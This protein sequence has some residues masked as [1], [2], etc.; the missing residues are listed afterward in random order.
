VTLSTRSSSDESGGTGE[1]PFSIDPE[2]VVGHVHLKVSDLE[3][4]I[5]FYRDVLGFEVTQRMGERAAFLGAGGYHHHIGLNTWESA[6]GSAPAP[7]TTGL[8]HAAFRYPDRAAL[9][10]ALRRLIRHGV[11]LDGAADHGVSE[12]LYLRDPDGNGVELYCDRPRN[13]WPRGPSGDIAMFT[14]PLDLEALL[15]A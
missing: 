2:V 5:A 10:V 4:A 8:Y 7:G 11:V 6:G 3:R 12:A 15:R 9:A 1:G 14:R 13:A